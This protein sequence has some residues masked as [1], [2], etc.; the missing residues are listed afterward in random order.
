MTTVRRRSSAV[1]KTTK[2]PDLGAL[3]KSFTEFRRLK[4]AETAAKQQHEKLRDEELMPA[5][6]AHG[7]PHGEQGQH[8]ALELPEPIDGFVRI[9]RRRNVS[10]SLD[11]DAAEALAE[12]KGVLQ[13]VQ[14]G[15]IRV[16]GI[17]ADKLAG[18][19][20][21]IA[22]LEKVGTVDVKVELD[23]D[24]LFAVHQADRERITEAELDKLFVEDVRYSF[25]PEK[26]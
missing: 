4:V 6:V 15:S 20:K 21:L 14:T 26:S 23:Q 17:P 13:E 12:E 11:I 19:E 24:K 5:L 22:Q 3:V 10:T 8:L 2:G 7:Q 25:V 1:S 18:L 9:V 16:D